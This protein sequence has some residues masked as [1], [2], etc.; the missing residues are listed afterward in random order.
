M[1]LKKPT[2]TI[3]VTNDL[4]L[5]QRMAY[6]V[7]LKHYYTA[8]KPK[9]G[10]RGIAIADLCKLMGYQKKDFF[11]L[12]EELF[13]LQ[14]T[15]IQWVGDKEGEFRRV[16]FFSFTKLEDGIFYYDF[17][18]EL[19][20]H[21]KNKKNSFNLLELGAMRLLK[22]KHSIA[23]Y[24]VVAG[25]RPNAKSGFRYGT[26]LYGVDDLREMLTGGTGKY[27][28]FKEFNRF[29][30]KNAVAEINAKTD[31]YLEIEVKKRGRSVIGVRFEVTDNTT[32]DTRK[33][34]VPTVRKIKPLGYVKAEYIDPPIGGDED[35]F[36][37][38]KDLWSQ[39]KED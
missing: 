12:D 4:S 31:L 36:E 17:H 24:E 35:A 27:P 37:T 13:K 10:Y 34:K 38:A 28:L 5:V 16:N 39:L 26:P 33:N 30:L 2:S 32:Y 6:S 25:Y 9:D 3:E 22:K 15:I 1:D 14:K 8:E 7:V 11:Y 20:R 19:E 23:L 21:I 29:I 18:P